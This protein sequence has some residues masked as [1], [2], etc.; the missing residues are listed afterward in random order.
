MQRFCQRFAQYESLVLV[1][2]Q[3]LDEIH[4]LLKYTSPQS[5]AVLSS[6][7]VRSCVAFSIVR[8]SYVCAYWCALFS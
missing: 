3:L 2:M 4:L 7:A 6:T 8:H 5:I 1:K